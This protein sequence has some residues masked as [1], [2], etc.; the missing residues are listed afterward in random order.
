MASLFTR[1]DVARTILVFGS[2]YILRIEN[3]F[4]DVDKSPIQGIFSMIADTCS[5]CGIG[6]F[7]LMLPFAALFTNDGSVRIPELNGLSALL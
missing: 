1:S 5:N 7:G 3:A 4:R 6:R 2:D